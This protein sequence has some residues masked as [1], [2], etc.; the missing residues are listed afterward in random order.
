M[1]VFGAAIVAGCSGGGETGGGTDAPTAGGDPASETPT[2]G[3]AG[4]ESASTPPS[5]ADPRAL[6]PEPPE[7]WEQGELVEQTADSLESVGAE[8]GYGAFY[9]DADG[10]EYF[11]E[12]LRWP[13][14]GDAESAWEETYSDSPSWVVYVTRN[15]FS[16]AANGPDA[17][18]VEDQVVTLVGNSPALT[19]GYVDGNN[20]VG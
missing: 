15:N 6:L 18:G 1:A 3:G 20:R 7:G 8:A 19:D 13:S 4:A 12:I 16:F 10:G 9:T 11:V 5:D 14:A 17:D 2:A